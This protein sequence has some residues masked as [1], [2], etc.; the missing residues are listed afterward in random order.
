MPALVAAA[1]A[2]IALLVGAE[3]DGLSDVATAAVDR[4]VR[5]PMARSV[6]SVNVATA[7][8][9]ALSALYQGELASTPPD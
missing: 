5:I 8:A 1:P 3:G 7:A 6:D 2:R 9:I 4:R